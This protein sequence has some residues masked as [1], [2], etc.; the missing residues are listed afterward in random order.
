[1]GTQ[2]YELF[3]YSSYAS[4]AAMAVVMCLITVVGVALAFVMGGAGAMNRA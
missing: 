4:A 1:M 2:L 3:N